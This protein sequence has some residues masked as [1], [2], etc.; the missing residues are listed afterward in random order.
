LI[1][2][3]S[4]IWCLQCGLSQKNELSWS[5]PHWSIHPFNNWNIWMFTETSWCVLTWLCQCHLELEMAKGLFSFCFGYFFSSKKFNHIAKNASIFH[6]KSSSWCK[7][8]SSFSTSTPL[9]HT[10]HHH[11]W[12]IAGGQFFDMKYYRPTTWGW[13]LTWK[14]FDI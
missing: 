11:D 14:D 3:N 5:A 13:F 1:L 7:P 4:R 12:P 2:C 9:G 8:I 6:L 10:S